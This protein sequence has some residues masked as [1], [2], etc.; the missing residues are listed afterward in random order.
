MRV[1]LDTNVV[2]AGLLY[3][4]T[5][6]RLLEAVVAGRVTCFASRALLAELRR[7]L[8]YPRLAPRV[9]MM[10]AS[11]DEMA[12]HFESFIKEVLAPDI[13]RSVPADPDDDH[14]LACAMAARADLIVSG[15]NDL[16]SLQSFQGMR[17][18]TP[19]EA[20]RLIEEA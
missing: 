8:R 18:V 13:P 17:V 16:L 20:L 4:G 7:V 2:V 5:P 10:D 9:A 1:V 6:N 12:E 14:V 19:A 3:R 11:V 15:D